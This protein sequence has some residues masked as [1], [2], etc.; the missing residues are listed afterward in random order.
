MPTASTLTPSARLPTTASYR[1]GAATGIGT[2]NVAPAFRCRRY[3]TIVMR[4]G[5]CQELPSCVSQG[6]IELNPD[7]ISARMKLMTVRTVLIG[8]RRC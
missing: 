1:R 2:P 7:I 6:R 8:K 3:L 4:G 5:H